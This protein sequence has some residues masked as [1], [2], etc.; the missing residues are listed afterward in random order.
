MRQRGAE[1]ENGSFVV[2]EL[3]LFES[4]RYNDRFFRSLK[5]GVINDDTI[6][7]LADDIL[8]TN[9][10]G[11]SSDAIARSSSPV[12]T[13]DD[14]VDRRRDAVEIARGFDNKRF[15]FIMKIVEE[16]PSIHSDDIT[17][18]VTGYTDRVDCSRMTRSL[19]E[20]M[21]FYVNS[22]LETSSERATNNNQLLGYGNYASTGSRLFMLRPQDV[23]SKFSFTK[24]D[25]LQDGIR[26]S[27]RSDQVNDRLITTN[28]RHNTVPSN[29]LSRS[30]TGLHK[31]RMEVLGED[32]IRER[33][34]DN[35]AGALLG[36]SRRNTGIS[37]G[38]EIEDE[39]ER[40][41]T[42]V[43]ET[44]ADEYQFLRSLRRAARDSGGSRAGVFTFRQLRRL[45]PD[46]ETVATV[47]LTKETGRTRTGLL[48]VDLSR[49]GDMDGEQWGSSG[50]TEEIIA[51]NVANALTAVCMGTFILI[52]DI[53]FA[54]RYDEY[55]QRMVWDYEI[56]YDD[57]G[58][59]E[60]GALLFAD[61]VS[62]DMQEVLISRFAKVMIDDVL[63]A[64]RR[65]GTEILIGV[66]YNMNREIFISVA[67]D[68]DE[69]YELCTPVFCD[70]LTT[71]TVTLNEHTTRKLGEGVVQL[72]Q[73]VYREISRG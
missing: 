43:S 19:P 64:Y 28:S 4:G 3:Y 52:V 6:D 71:P 22:F 58:H 18:L 67:I 69:P 36:R 66:R 20:D 30:L 48:D 11:F 72:Y 57:R 60:A 41:R 39:L 23:I 8:R 70:S 29:Y 42:V 63:N 51:T 24:N 59:T 25:G 1:S 7:T 5:F 55:E 73:N 27:Y 33:E 68:T 15:C 12:I 40:V 2:T 31:N 46:I 9:G 14:E 32:L 61:N 10:T 47:S 49:V 21:E 56:A 62:D 34:D 53:M 35:P 44:Q 50:S 45:V 65:F 26:R 17:Y 54:L 13:L 38:A 37:R 16:A